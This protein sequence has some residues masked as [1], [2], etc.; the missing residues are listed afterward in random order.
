MEGGLW[1]TGMCILQYRGVSLL[2]RVQK[3]SSFLQE[4]F[5]YKL[6]IFF[7]FFSSTFFLNLLV[8]SKEIGVAMNSDEYVPTMIPTNKAENESLD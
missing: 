6:E 5:L 4:L 2:S 7:Y 3:N 1:D 8:K